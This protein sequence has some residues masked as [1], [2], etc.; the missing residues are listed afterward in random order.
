MK[1]GMKTG[2]Y[3]TAQGVFAT[4]HSR[5]EASFWGFLWVAAKKKVKTPG[6]VILSF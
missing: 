2:M 6:S 4:R 1:K 3:S 5:G